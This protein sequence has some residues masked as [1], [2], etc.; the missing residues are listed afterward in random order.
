MSLQD[1]IENAPGPTDGGGLPRTLP[2]TL[3]RGLERRDWANHAL[4]ATAREPLAVLDDNLRV[5][6][7]SRAYHR[8]LPPSLPGRLFC[9]PPALGWSDVAR[10]ILDDVMARNI[11]VE[12]V[13][14]ELDIAPHGP[15]RMLLNARPVG[16]RAN[17]EAALVIGLQDITD[18]RENERLKI[19]LAHQQSVFL[20]EAHHRIANSLQIIASILLLKARSVTSEETRMHLRDVHKR[21]IL[22]ATVQRQLCANGMLEDIEF[23]PYVAQLCL[24]LADSMTEGDDR[25]AIVTASTGGR[26]K[27]DDAISFGLIVTELVI[28]AL[29]HGYPDGRHGRIAVDFAANGADWRLSVSDDGVGRVQDATAS[30]TG[31]GTNI[32]EALARHLKARV[33]IGAQAVGCTTTI[34]HEEHAGATA[35]SAS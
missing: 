6:A 4:T 15:R 14:I 5:L 29:K 10:Q 18:L 34:I 22:V 24:G 7:A 23:G 21:L 8:L 20:Q 35:Q 25:V 33:E 30:H 13:E 12:D 9:E 27:S 26:I 3:P 16:D 2:H 1:R 17:P 31:L 28:N 32:V 11:A 19:E